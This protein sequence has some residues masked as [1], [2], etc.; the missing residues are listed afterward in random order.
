[1]LSSEEEPR[2]S[3]LVSSG[4]TGSRRAGLLVMNADRSLTVAAL[5]WTTDRLLTRA[6]L[7]STC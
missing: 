7:I 1:M 5:I 3:A 2:G 6:A 4:K